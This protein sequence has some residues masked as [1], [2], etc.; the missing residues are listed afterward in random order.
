MNRDPNLTRIAE[1]IKHQQHKHTHSPIPATTATPEEEKTFLDSTWKALLACWQPGGT[2]GID[3][4][5]KFVASK[6]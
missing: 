3:V 1:Y 4:Y 6:F 5:M 2:R